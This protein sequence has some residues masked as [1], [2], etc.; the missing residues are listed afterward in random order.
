MPEPAD[1]YE[2][3]VADFR[4]EVPEGYNIA[5]DVCDR[6]ALSEPDRTA[7]LVLG[8]DDRRFVDD[9]F[10]HTIVIEILAQRANSVIEDR[11]VA[12]RGVHLRPSP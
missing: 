1:T 5:A 12:E 4:W 8:A 2:Q 6:W 11:R 9:D 10:G 3:C 7:L